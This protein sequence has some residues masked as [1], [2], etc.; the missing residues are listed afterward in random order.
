MRKLGLSRVE[1][2]TQPGS[3]WKI[4]LGMVSEAALSVAQK[5]PWPQVVPPVQLPGPATKVLTQPS[6]KT[7]GTTPS[8]FS[9]KT[10]PQGVGAGIAPG[11]MSTGVKQETS[12]AVAGTVSEAT[13]KRAIPFSW[14]PRRKRRSTESPGASGVPSETEFTESELL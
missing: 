5:D 11:V 8:K 13:Q 6:G 3:S 2:V 1:S 4:E 7:G 9:L 14:T 10:V 12:A